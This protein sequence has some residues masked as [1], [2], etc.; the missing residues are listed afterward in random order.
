MVFSAPLREHLPSCGEQGCCSKIS[1]TWIPNHTRSPPQAFVHAA[2]VGGQS[3]FCVC[4]CSDAFRP[5]SSTPAILRRWAGRHVRDA[6][7]LQGRKVRVEDLPQGSFDSSL[8]FH[9]EA[10]KRARLEY[11]GGFVFL[12]PRSARRKDDTR[13][14]TLRGCSRLL[15]SSPPQ[16]YEEEIGGVRGHFG[17][18][19]AL[20]VSPDGR[21]FTSGGEDG[22]VRVNHFDADYFKLKV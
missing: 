14:L 16:I 13:P 15:L 9:R 8:I 7:Q 2:D 20:G 5:G 12:E 17:P 22:Y 10:A 3:M 1:S 11:C 6:H 18:I 19:N 21:S 4:G